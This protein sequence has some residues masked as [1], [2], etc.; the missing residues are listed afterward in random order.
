MDRR[1][2]YQTH[3]TL[4]EFKSSR[5]LRNYDSNADKVK[6]YESVKKGLAE[7]YEDQ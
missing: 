5:K 4:Q 2:N 7:I 1:Q 3:K 6:L